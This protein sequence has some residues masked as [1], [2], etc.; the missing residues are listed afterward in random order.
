MHIVRHKQGG[1]GMVSH[2]YD[3]DMLTDEISQVHGS[4][5]FITS[6]LTG[7]RED[8]VL[9]REFEASHGTVTDLYHKMLRGEETSLNPLGLIE[10]LIGAMRHAADLHPTY[11]NEIKE[12]T[13][14]LR[15]TIQRAYAGGF[16][17][18]D[19]AG[20]KGLTTEQFVARVASWLKELVPAFEPKPSQLDDDALAVLF[21]ELDKSG[22]GYVSLDEFVTGL[23]RLGIKVPPELWSNKLPTGQ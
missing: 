10:A 15:T 8:G 16:G 14:L 9:I 12:F 21:K 22:D 20:E 18:R 11:K 17:T 4:P 3:G 2:N 5:G 19:L 13:R 7:K 6:N 23:K 1:F